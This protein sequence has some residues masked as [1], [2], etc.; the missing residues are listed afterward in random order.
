[1]QE[2]MDSLTELEVHVEDNPPADKKK[3]LKLRWLLGT[4]R[5][6]TGKIKRRKVCIIVGGHEQLQGVNYKDTFAP[7]PT[8]ASLRAALTIAAK[9]NWPT[10]SFDVKTAYLLSKIDG[11]VWVQP[12]PGHPTTPGKVWKLRKALDPKPTSPAI[13]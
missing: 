2:E 13:K 3:L 5:T 10:A 6:M 1:M 12:P 8:F 7:N 11:D 4:K 9:N